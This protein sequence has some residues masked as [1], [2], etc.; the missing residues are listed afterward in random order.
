MSLKNRLIISITDIHG[1]RSYNFSDAIKKIVKYSIISIILVLCLGFLSIVLLTKSLNSLEKK[2]DSL[3]ARLMTLDSTNKK[4]NNNIETKA[5]ELQYLNEKIIDVEKIVG[6]TPYDKNDTGFDS[7]IDTAKLTYAEKQYM[8]KVIPSGYPIPKRG[9]SSSYGWR[10]HPVLKRR[11]FHPG[12][13]L[14]AKMRTKVRAPADGIIKYAGFNKKGYGNIVIMSHNFGFETLYAHLYKSKVKVGDIINKGDVIALTGNSGLS[15]GP[16]LHYEVRY[17]Q[18]N[19]RPAWFLRW[20]ISHY[21]ELFKKQRKVK[22]QSL[23][24]QIKK[25]TASLKQL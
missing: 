19:L 11:D 24:A 12:I 18:R 7:R 3:V 8:V 25:Q 15:S 23:I 16:H 14:R 21:D 20:T 10:T 5:K 13:D 6:I 1:T 2:K 17:A 22:W 9:V 4:L